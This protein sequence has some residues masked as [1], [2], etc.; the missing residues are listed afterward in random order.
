MVPSS[1]AGFGQRRVQDQPRTGYCLDLNVIDLER[2]RGR[3]SEQCE[4]YGYS[5]APIGC[6]RLRDGMEDGPRAEKKLTHC[7]Y[8]KV[9]RMVI[10]TDILPCVAVV[11]C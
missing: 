8:R 5:T 7:I 6:D 4:H 10:R 3:P 1:V 11:E 9:A 2:G